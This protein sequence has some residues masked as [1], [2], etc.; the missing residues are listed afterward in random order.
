MG[1]SDSNT[2]VDEN[3]VYD[4][5][6]QV[7][8]DNVTNDNNP[9]NKVNFHS[10]EPNETIGDDDLVI[11]KSS[12]EE[13]HWGRNSYARALI[14]LDVKYDLKD[15]LIVVV[16]LL[17]GEGCTY[18]MIGR[19]DGVFPNMSS[20]QGI[21]DQVMAWASSLVTSGLCENLGKLQPKADI[22]IF[23]G[24]A[25]TKKAF[26]IYNRRTRRIVETIYVDF[27]E[28]TA[29]AS[30]Q[31]RSGPAL[32]EMTPETISSGLV[33]TTSPSTSYVPPSRND[34]DLLFQPMFDELLN[35]PP[36]VVN[37]A[38]ED[39]APIIEV[40]PPVNA[41]STGSHSSTTVEQDAPSTSNSTTPTKTQS[42]IIPQDVGDDNLDIK[43]AHMGS[44]LLFG[45]AI[46]EVNSEQSTTPVSPQ[47]IV[48]TDYPL[49]H[50]N[51]K[52][53]KD[54]PLNNI[55]G[56]LDRPVS[57]RLQLHEQALFCYYGAFLTSVELKTYKEALTQSCW[58]EVMQDEL[59]EF[60]R[61]KVWELVPRP[62]K[63]MVITLKWIYKSLF[64]AFGSLTNTS[65][66][67]KINYLERQMIDGK[68]VL[69]GYDGMPLNMG[70]SNT[71]MGSSDSNTNVD[72]N[73]VH[74]SHWGRNSYAR[75]LIELDVKYDLKD[76]LIVVVLLLEGEGCTYIMIGV[77]Y[78]WTPPIGTSNLAPKVKE[79]STSGNKVSTTSTPTLK[80]CTANSFGVL[81]LMDM[82]STHMDDH[83]PIAKCKLEMMMDKGLR[84]IRW[85]H[86]LMRKVIVKWKRC[87]MKSQVLWNQRV[88]R[89]L[90]LLLVEM[91]LG[92]KTE[93][94][95]GGEWN[96]DVGMDMKMTGFAICGRREIYIP[97]PLPPAAIVEPKKDDN[98]KVEK[99]FVER[100]SQAK[101]SQA[102]KHDD[103]ST[104]S[105]LAA[106]SNSISNM[107]APANERVY[108]LY[109]QDDEMQSEIRCGCGWE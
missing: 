80:V 65:L 102:T 93:S 37:Q 109:V 66:A 64:E 34:W 21:Q 17:E 9:M 22:G 41:D 56:Q 50:H 3:I 11:P 96:R 2:N 70:R 103:Y 15:N 73:I 26:R 95:R 30:E 67:A 47:A 88:S 42:S 35:P 100:S 99:V 5:G 25:S 61:L 46:L 91:V 94:R 63:V 75:A 106:A 77:E 98:T 69:L 8:Y 45:I 79:A 19:H 84:R 10:L 71:C 24:Y 108:V 74:D 28:L 81:C 60:V 6:T 54:H 44:D 78:E 105:I 76:N 68:L 59:H 18:I 36:S 12:F 52:W 104:L 48:Q 7:S 62:D 1:S 29:M 23:I 97:R 57:T 83:V 43:V 49:P 20:V 87:T 32:N 4:V 72:D 92:I 85:T 51:C 58:I 107:L 89:V 55:I 27:D 40:I 33:H 38:P 82:E 39:I 90:K 13:S 31:R 86:W 14:E 53:T 16:L 101:K